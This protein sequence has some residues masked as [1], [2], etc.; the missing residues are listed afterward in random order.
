M[1]LYSGQITQLAAFRHVRR[2]RFA[3]SRPAVT[4]RRDRAACADP[5]AASKRC[6]IPRSSTETVSALAVQSALAALNRARS[7]E[8][9]SYGRCIIG[10]T[11]RYFL[12][13]V[14][15]ANEPVD[16]RR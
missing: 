15:C 9:V 13:R 16:R 6:S 8:R 11:R 1:L 2:S 3:D 4:V 14:P 12:I 10:R 5:S 7:H